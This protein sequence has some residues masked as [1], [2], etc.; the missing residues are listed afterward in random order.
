MTHCSAHQSTI[1][2]AL[3][4]D[5]ETESQDDGVGD[6]FDEKNFDGVGLYDIDGPINTRWSVERLPLLQTTDLTSKLQRYLYL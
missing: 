5:T 4:D 2:E 6:F 3:G 1:A